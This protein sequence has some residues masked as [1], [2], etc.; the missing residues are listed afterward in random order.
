MKNKEKVLSEANKRGK[1]FGSG[2]IFQREDFWG[3][4]KHLT[5][6]RSSSTEVK[7]TR[8]DDFRDVFK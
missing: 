2:N 1:R 3:R 7:G 8:G 5:S 6:S 4:V